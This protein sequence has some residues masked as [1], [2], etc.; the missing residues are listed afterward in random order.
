M[1]ADG[2]AD[3]SIPITQ[4]RASHACECGW[5]ARSAVPDRP[6]TTAMRCQDLLNEHV[7]TID[8]STPDY[9]AVTNYAGMQGYSQSGDGGSYK[10]KNSGGHEDTTA[11]SPNDLWPHGTCCNGAQS[12]RTRDTRAILKHSRPS[13]PLR[14][15][16]AAGRAAHRRPTR[17]ATSSSLPIT[18]WATVPDALH[19]LYSPSTR[20]TECTPSFYKFHRASHA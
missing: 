12:L 14:A 5:H 13:P 1:P 20:R 17:T 6:V 16:Q 10:C 2:G 3:K 19:I 15:T 18:P 9:E 7:L 11:D 4:V 8:P